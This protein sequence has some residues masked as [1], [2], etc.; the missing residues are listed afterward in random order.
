MAKKSVTEW[1]P[2]GVAKP[3]ARALAAAG[4]KSLRDLEKLGESELAGLHGMGPKAVGV[5]K[6]ALKAKGLTLKK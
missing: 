6:D 5:L 2:R 1:P 4:V 3:A